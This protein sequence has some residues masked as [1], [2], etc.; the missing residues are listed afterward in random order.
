MPVAADEL[1]AVGSVGGCTGTLITQ[2]LVLTAAHCVCS[3][4]TEPTGC[5]PRAVF[6]FLNVFP[7]ANPAARANVM[8]GADVT[9]HP[10]YTV[11]GWLRND[12]ALLRL[13]RRADEVVLGVAPIPVERPDRMPRVG[14]T[15]TLVGLGLTGPTC[16][17]GG[18]GKLKTDVSVSEISEATIVFNNS[19]RHACPGDSGGPALNRRGNVVGVASSSDLATNSNY[20]PTF[21]AYEWIFGTGRILRATGRLTMLRV[22]DVGSGYGPSTDPID[23][24]VVIQLE[25]DGEAA[26]GFPLRV[27]AGEAAH[28]RM[29]GLLLDAFAHSRTLSIEYEV[30]GPHNGRL[31][32]VLRVL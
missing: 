19:D 3:G 4:Q 10:Q 2:R 17:S 23:G 12:Y 15:L 26:F 16:K 30:T 18:A 24:E 14:E 21:A 11:G 5:R 1:Q 28:Q 6:T 27:G 9:V 25:N 13:D 20:D 7:V 32:R 22:H 31:L 29:L 8:V